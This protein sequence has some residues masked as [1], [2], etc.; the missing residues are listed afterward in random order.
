MT[1]SDLCF[2]PAVELAMLIRRPTSQL[3]SDDFPTFGRP[4]MATTGNPAWAPTSSS[5]PS[6]R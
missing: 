4:T 5:T 1:A 6:E 2:T 3:N